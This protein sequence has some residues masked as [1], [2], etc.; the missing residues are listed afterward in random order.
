M[1]SV[2][3]RQGPPSGESPCLTLCCGSEL[4]TAF[5]EVRGIA[6]TALLALAMAGCTRSVMSPSEFTE[7]SAAA[8]RAA[9]PELKVKVSR[10]LELR[11]TYHTNHENTCFLDNAYAAYKQA[12]ARK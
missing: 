2:I 9:A 7:S 12:P 11:V 10:P 4:A 6:T 8:L 1:G 5:V 3:R